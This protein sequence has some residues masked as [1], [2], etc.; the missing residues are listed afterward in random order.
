MTTVRE[1]L[2][3]VE[4]IYPPRCAMR[5]DR[6]GLMVGSPG[7]RVRSVL[8]A[9][10]PDVP[11]VEAARKA[12]AELVIA[13]H[14][15][16]WKPPRTLEAHEPTGRGA[17]KAAASGIAVIAAHTNADFAPGGLC[18]GLAELCG[19]DA[20][21]PIL[22]EGEAPIGRV[23]NL[24]HPAPTRR[25]LASLRRRFGAG[26]RVCGIPSVRIGRVAVCSGSGSDLL[27]AAFAS[28]ADA[29]VTGDVKY[30]AGRDAEELARTRRDEQGSSHGFLLVDAGHFGTERFFVPRTVK[31][32]Q[33]VLPQLLIRGF[34]D[35]D[36]FRS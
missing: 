1:I 27:T 8:V 10:D 34:V 13:H 16:W 20:A 29:L 2:R 7:R 17:V 9:L 24:K 15:I 31:K 36:P 14:P 5:D 21:E 4:E 19:L 33:A 25:W 26:L 6:I 23:G 32:L 12:G 3:A 22:R 35:R 28:G 30:H 18:D 11:A